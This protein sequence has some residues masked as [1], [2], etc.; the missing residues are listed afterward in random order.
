MVWLEQ[1]MERLPWMYYSVLC[2]VVFNVLDHMHRCHFLNKII[3]IPRCSIHLLRRQSLITKFLFPSKRPN[4]RKNRLILLLQSL[5]P[6]L[7]LFP[8]ATS[9]VQLHFPHLPPTPHHHVTIQPPHLL[10]CM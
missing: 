3:F 9:A 6:L 1:L 10:P 4:S 7:P 5:D 2:L 8:C